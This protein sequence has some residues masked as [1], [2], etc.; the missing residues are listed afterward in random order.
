MKVAK[1]GNYL[2]DVG[3]DNVATILE[4]E[5]GESVRSGRLVAWHL[6]YG[7][8]YLLHRDRVRK[9]RQVM[10]LRVKFIPIQIARSRVSLAHD[11]GKVAMNDGF[12]VCIVGDPSIIVLDPMD[13]IF[14]TP[15]IN[16]AVEELGVGITLFKVCNARALLFPG[17]TKPITLLL[18]LAQRSASVGERVRDS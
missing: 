10:H 15:G 6:V 13:M 11:L 7:V 2:H 18:S 8:T 9:G 5:A 3:F 14:P 4:K 17:T 1:K 16:P 12:S